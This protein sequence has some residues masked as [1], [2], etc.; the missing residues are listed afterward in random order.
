MWTHLAV[1][2]DGSAVTFHANAAP[3]GAAQTLAFSRSNLGDLLI[4]P[5]MQGL[6]DDARVYNAPL[7]SAQLAGLVEAQADAD[8]DGLSN[9][10]ESLYGLD[11]QADDAAL[12]ADSDG[13]SN[14][15]E[16]LTHGTDP[17][18]ADSDGDGAS[19]GYEVNTL[20]TNPLVADQGGAGGPAVTVLYPEE[21]A[22][23]LW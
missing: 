7:G 22:L 1:S 18:N 3:C 9:L 4:G 13:L 14:A 5:G 10:V 6:V 21:G 11:L 17:F 8:G 2:V 23:I 16:I 15:A 20:A 12:D 19:D